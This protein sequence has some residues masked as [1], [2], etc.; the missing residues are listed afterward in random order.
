MHGAPAAPPGVKQNIDDPPLLDTQA[1]EAIEKAA[2]ELRKRR[3][4]IATEP[5]TVYR[6]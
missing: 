5:P 6:P 2:A 4:A 3:V 1:H